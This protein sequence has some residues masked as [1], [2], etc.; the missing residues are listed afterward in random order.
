MPDLDIRLARSR[1]GPARRDRAAAAGHR[2]PSRPPASAAGGAAAAAPPR[3]R[4]SA[5]SASAPGPGSSDTTPSVT[6]TAAP[7]NA[8]V[9][10]GDGIKIIGLAPNPVFD[11]DG[12]IADVEFTDATTAWWP[13]AATNACPPLASTSDGGLSWQTVPGSPTDDGL[14]DLVA[15]PDGR[16]LLVADGAYW[17]SGTGDRLAADHP[18]RAGHPRPDRAGRAAPAGQTRSDGVVVWSPDQGPL[19]PLAMQPTLTV[20][21]VAPAPA[22]DGAWWVGGVAGSRPAVAVSHD[23]GAQLER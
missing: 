4:W 3:S 23:A 18:A 1:A 13:P 7:T 10:R 2:P 22:G 9:Y 21:W 19:G 8:P 17:S 20:R 16:W 5:S 14:P 12:E 6:A 11:L 15:F